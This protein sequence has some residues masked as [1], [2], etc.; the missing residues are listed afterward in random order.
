MY[1]SFYYSISCIYWLICAGCLTILINNMLLR[2]YMDFFH[3]APGG[4]LYGGISM[5]LFQYVRKTKLYVLL[6]IVMLLAGIFTVPS[7]RAESLV[8]LT[9]TVLSTTY[10]KLSWT[11]QLTNETKFKV[12]RKTDSGSFT[13]VALLSANTTIYYDSAVT[14]GYTY[15]YRISYYDA[16]G[17]LSAYTSEVAATTTAV[18]RPLS[19]TTTPVSVT[20]IQLNWS[21]A[22]NVTFHTIIERK[23]ST[24]QAWTVAAAVSGGETGYRDT[25]LAEGTIYLYRIRAVLGSNVHS[26]YYPSDYGEL[27]YTQYRAPSELYG[28]AASPTQIY[29]LWKDNSN[30]ASFTVE[31]KTGDTG[32][33]AVVATL[34]ANTTLWRDSS[35]APDTR[36]TYRV[37]A[38]N[39]SIVS[40]YSEELFLTSKFLEQPVNLSAKMD[41]KQNIELVWTDNA[42]TETGFE[43]WRRS[44][45]SS[46]WEKYASTGR[47]VTKYIDKNVYSEIQYYY[48]VRARIS[49]SGVYSAFSNEASAW[50]LQMLP[51]T[52]LDYSVTNPNAITLEW[53]EQSNNESGYIV[54][55]KT[56]IDGK[57]VEIAILPANTTYYTDKAVVPYTQ[58]L[59]RIKVFENT[60][61]NASAAS[62][63][64]IISTGIPKPAADLKISGVSST[65][66]LLKWVDASDNELGYIIER[67]P[68]DLLGY[69]EIARVGPDTTS[70]QDKEL[71]PG[72]YYYRVKAYNKTGSSTAGREILAATSEAVSFRDIPEGFWAR[73]EIENLASRGIFKTRTNGLFG[74]Q[75]AVTRGEFVYL[76]VQTLKLEKTA[77]GSF[78]DVGPRHPYY[79]EIMIAGKMGIVNANRQNYFFPD[80]L[81]TREEMAQMV[82]KALKAIDKPLPAYDTS[83]LEEYSDK[84]DISSGLEY[85]VASIC[86]ERI[87]AGKAQGGKR[88][89]APKA[90]TVRAEVAVVLYKIIDR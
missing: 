18:S 14:P 57:W 86:A 41:S 40:D 73:T 6:F 58:Y 43:I 45:T 4:L 76:L 61:Y 87:M 50:Y 48:K 65:H 39:G 9:V 55:R 21:Y 28:F 54:E 30:E 38:V 49:H 37:K 33:Y 85:S 47:N 44:G 32:T 71:K 66:I 70:Y 72:K 69:K 79:K 16:S 63:E 3:T 81:M 74:P 35:L 29:L 34:P 77:S 36:Y 19:L 2:A 56:G 17:N 68:Y 15:T 26:T 83:I 82:V 88:I 53:V 90:I 89:F 8:D 60:Y 52:D 80:Q 59:Y 64:I 10:V 78:T 46:N 13:E 75:D 23:T 5:L 25:G 42:R 84:D 24:E 51:P 20:E 12:E 62:R 67:K 11:D 31:R 7:V 27:T 1:I 22:G